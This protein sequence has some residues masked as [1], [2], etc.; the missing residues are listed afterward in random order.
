[1]HSR[2]S[3]RSHAFL[4]LLSISFRRHRTIMSYTEPAAAM[5]GGPNT[6]PNILQTSLAAQPES[7]RQL[8]NRLFEPT[9][10]TVP[11]IHPSYKSL[12]RCA[13]VCVGVGV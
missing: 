9:D 5:V 10:D 6:A 12:G 8:V 1:M 7:I 11:V 4:K 13:C 2:L 3:C